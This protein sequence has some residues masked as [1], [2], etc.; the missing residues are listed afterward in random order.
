MK[1]EYWDLDTEAEMLTNGTGMPP[2][3]QLEC[4]PDFN[5]ENKTKMW[6]V[7]LGM[8]SGHDCT[9][10]VAT[11]CAGNR[12]IKTHRAHSLSLLSIS[13]RGLS[14][15]SGPGRT[16]PG[17]PPGPIC[18]TSPLSRA[19]LGSSLTRH[20]IFGQSGLFGLSHLGAPH[21]I[22]A[23]L[24]IDRSLIEVGCRFKGDI[25]LEERNLLQR[26]PPSCSTF[27]FDSFSPSRLYSDSFFAAVVCTGSHLF[28]ILFSANSLP[29]L[30]VYKREY[31]RLTQLK[32][33]TFE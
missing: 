24:H 27:P 10:W 13:G 4:I 23:D 28:Q 16:R 30:P 2:R 33:Y 9:T 1:R 7:G 5:M 29:S 21:Y 8:R 32:K 31:E 26:S 3:R 14:Y 6:K 18:H 11:G 25:Q 22:L 17:S 19:L 20:L 12:D 15:P